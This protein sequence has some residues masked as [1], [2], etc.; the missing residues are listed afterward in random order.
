[1]PVDS[2]DEYLLHKLGDSP[3][4]IRVTLQVQGLPLEM[5]VDTGADISIIADQ[6]RKSYFPKLRLHPSSV[7]LKTYTGEPVPVVGQLNMKVQHGEQEA[8]LVLV[9][10]T[11]NGPTLLGR[12]WLKYLRLD[13]KQISQ[14]HSVK[15]QQLHT[16]L[17]R[18]SSVFQDG[19]GSI[20]PYRVSL[21]VQDDTKPKFY[22]AQPVPFATKDAVGRE[23]D[24]LENEGI[25]EKV[26][27]SDW[28]TPIVTVPKKD[29]TYRICGDYRLMVNPVMAIEQYPLPCPE[30]LFATLS[31]G[32]VLTK[33]DLSQAY[34]Q[35][36]LDET[37]TKLTTIN[38]HQGLYQYRRLPFG[39]ASAPALFQ[40]LMDTVLQGKQGVICYIDNISSSEVAE[41]LSTLDSVLDCLQ[42]HGF[43]LRKDKCRFLMPSVEYLGHIVDASGIRATLEKVDAILQAPPPTNTT[44]LRAFLGLV[45]YYG[46]FVSNLATLLRPLNDLLESD[47]KWVWSQECAQAFAETKEKLVSTLVLTHYNPDLP[48]NL[49]TDASAYG[50]G[51][52]ISHVSSDGTERPIAFASRSLTDSERNYAQIEKVA[53]LLVFGVKRF[54]QFLYGRK[55]SLITDHKSLTAIFGP[56]KGIPALAA[57]RLQRWAVLLSAYYY[58][59]SYKPS[60]LHSNADGLSRLP[61]PTNRSASTDN[62]CKLFNIGQ[63]QALPVTVAD[64][65]K[66][67]PSD[68]LLSRVCEY[69]LKGC[70]SQVP[71]ELH[72]FKDKQNELSLEVVC[73][74]WGIRVVIP[75]ALKAVVLQSL[76]F[77]HPGTTRMKAVARSY[78]WWGGLDKDIESI[79]KTCNACQAMKSSPPVAPLHPWV[80]PNAPW[81]RLHLDF[82]GP[83]LGKMLFVLVDAHSM[84]PEVAIMSS[85]TFASTIE[86]L[87]SLFARYGLPEQVV[88]DN[89]PQF[90]SD[91]FAQFLKLNGV[92]HIRSAPY[93]PAS[94]GQVER[95]IQT[96]KRALKLSES[97]G[98]SFSRHLSQFLFEYRASPHATTN[99]PPS[100]LFL[101]RPL[102]TQSDLLR[103]NV[104]S[105]VL[106][107]QA[108]QKLNFDRRSKSRLFVVGQSVMVK[109]HRSNTSKWSRG[110]IINQFGPVTYSVDVQ[111]HVVKCHVDQLRG[112]PESIADVVS[113]SSGSV[114]DNFVIL[115]VLQLTT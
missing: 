2:D 59:I 63:I 79:S 44:E 110:I 94:N 36:Q 62:V 103:P 97:S 27:H 90:T 61:L 19:L 50:V 69:V 26:M 99:R 57:A 15:M 71:P 55:S 92:K 78:F 87:R 3:D 98:Q 93:H 46:K 34:L 114:E 68:R 20:E 74:M 54:H 1:M 47:T 43:R 40:K 111:G 21:Q 41:H 108:T 100:Q 17:D 91:E 23:L 86:V 113:G 53:L 106:S 102:R 70:P 56:K 29:G 33:L 10:V 72:M 35:Y 18:H 32:T 11:G 66:A 39:V 67:T 105:D 49:P 12:N 82:A 28:A 107:K 95:F 80:W 84:W 25:L 42:Q 96:L 104:N 14:L 51:A 4:A 31:G 22:K 115:T 58:H 37:S 65:Q 101:G 83:F 16:V 76:H 9:V 48:I 13:W 112:C 77:N 89:G 30:D 5:E 8:K 45:N 7:I 60:Q 6:T 38:T 64:V 81:K 85:T 88:S 109:V 73:L 52:V 24:R 75:E